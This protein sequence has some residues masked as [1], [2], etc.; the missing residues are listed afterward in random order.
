[1]RCPPA[2]DLPEADARKEPSFKVD[3][4]WL[5]TTEDAAMSDRDERIR[6][7]AYEIWERE[8]RPGGMEEK[9]WHQ[10]AEEIAAEEGRTPASPAKRRAP[11]TRKPKDT[12]F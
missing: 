1:M 2:A 3:V 12:K 10:A 5:A 6:Q 11:S 7:R 4:L 9:H 8:G